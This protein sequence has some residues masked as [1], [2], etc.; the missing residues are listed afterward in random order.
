MFLF[1]LF[2]IIK[3]FLE[4]FEFTFLFEVVKST[5]I[6]GKEV[7]GVAIID[8]TFKQSRFDAICLAMMKDDARMFYSVEFIFTSVYC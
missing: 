8:S 2:L 7:N 4:P 6:D 5:G 1:G 3:C